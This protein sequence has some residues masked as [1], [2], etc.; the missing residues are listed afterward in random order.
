MMWTRRA[1]VMIRKPI[2]DYIE[3][4]YYTAALA[5]LGIRTRRRMPH[6]SEEGQTWRSPPHPRGHVQRVYRRGG[7]P[8]SRDDEPARAP[9]AASR[10]SVWVHGRHP[11]QQRFESRTGFRHPGLNSIAISP[12]DNLKSIQTGPTCVV[13]Q[14]TPDSLKLVIL[15]EPIANNNCARPGSDRGYVGG[16]DQHDRS[17]SYLREADQGDSTKLT[18]DGVSGPFR[19]LYAESGT[20]TKLGRCPGPVGGP[21]GVSVAR[22]DGT[23]TGRRYSG[24]LWTGTQGA[25]VQWV[26]LNEPGVDSLL[27]ANDMVEVFSGRVGSLPI[28]P[29]HRRHLRREV[30]GRLS[31]WAALA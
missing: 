21:G 26:F 27:A 6:A 28:R 4:V 7:R 16:A 22:F 3:Q 12:A 15:Q 18:S 30:H 13:G 8:T 1:K 20:G 25:A 10:R 11:Q 2:A 23:R 24:H 5:G 9:M 31:P 17:G 14:A 29:T 19:I